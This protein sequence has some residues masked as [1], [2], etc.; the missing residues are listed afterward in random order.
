MN[1]TEKIVLENI[2]KNLRDSR[3]SNWIGSSDIYEWANYANKM[4]NTI[5]NSVEIIEGLLTLPTENE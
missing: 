2:V 3:R 1:A 4:S 5:S